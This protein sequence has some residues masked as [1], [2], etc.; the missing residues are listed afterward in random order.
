[1]RLRQFTKPLAE[2]LTDAYGGLGRSTLSIIGGFIGMMISLAILW[3]FTQVAL[4]GL[5]RFTAPAIASIAIISPN[6]TRS[7]T[8]AILSTTAQRQL[9]L[10]QA[11]AK[12][13]TALYIE[14]VED[15]YGI[16]ASGS[17]FPTKF[18]FFNR[19][20]ILIR[21]SETQTAHSTL[22]QNTPAATKYILQYRESS[23]LS[24]IMARPGPVRLD[25]SKANIE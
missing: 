20:K 6:E 21:V 13:D 2:G 5:S 10:G 4:Y 7:A 3:I 15:A 16:N 1:M 12:A 9:N 19:K 25:L 23:D 22:V 18:A 11:R 8:A 17:P 24:Q 14:P